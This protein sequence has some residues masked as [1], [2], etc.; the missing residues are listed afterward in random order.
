MIAEF[1]IVGLSIS[2]ALAST[3]VHSLWQNAL[4]GVIAM[5]ALRATPGTTA[6]GRHLAGMLFLV[7]M[8]VVPVIQFFY[9]ILHPAPSPML[10]LWDS[11]VLRAIGA[12]A[13]V[14]E[15]LPTPTPEIVVIAW[16][17]GAAV[18]T[19]RYMRGLYHVR[20]LERASSVA[21]PPMWQSRVEELRA[22]LG[23]SRSVVVRLSDSVL[24]PCA[25][26]LLRPVIWLPAS[27]LTG[28]PP[29]QIEAL[30][31]HELA[32]ISRRD[33]MWNG[34]QCV[35]ETVLFYHPAVW[36]LGKRIRHEREVASDNL[37]ADACGDP[38]AL[39]EALL[40]LER[41]RQASGPQ[42]VLAAAGGMLLPRVRNLLSESRSQNSG[43]TLFILAL[44]ISAGVAGF[45]HM[46]VAL[47]SLSDLHVQASTT[48]TLAA[49]DYRVIRAFDN[50]RFRRYQESVDLNGN[51]TEEY[52]EAGQI[53]PIDQEVRE[54]IERVMQLAP[55]DGEFLHP[56]I[57]AGHTD[58]DFDSN[59]WMHH[60]DEID[61][62]SDNTIAES[63]PASSRTKPR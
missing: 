45:S 47:E 18:M 4:V 30:L 22:V 32:H 44:V 28:M 36:W 6:A 42:P 34:I 14:F 33:W 26:R 38:V 25:A 31:A 56:D 52:R 35:I 58:P 48:G 2:E 37:A 39:A 21:L 60:E 63:L 5:V 53:R 57:E 1:P 13:N 46:T 59:E 8:V 10:R 11:G 29:S 19:S 61:G 50:G 54:W 16:L 7:A 12:P 15:D 55:K 49:G 43:L 62:L 20:T 27:M 40:N 41:T 23:I 51:R 9:C 17:L 24:V 3:I